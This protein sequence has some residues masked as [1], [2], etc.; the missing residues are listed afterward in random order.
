MQLIDAHTFDHVDYWFYEKESESVLSQ[1]CGCAALLQGGFVW[2]IAA[3]VL[4][5][6]CALN[7]P[8]GI[9]KDPC[10][11]FSVWDQNGQLLVD[12]E[13]TP[14]E[15]EVICGNYLCYTGR[16]NQMSKKSWFPL[17]HVYEGSREDHGRWTES[18]DT[19]YTNRIGAISG[20]CPNAAFCELLTSTMWRLR[21]RGTPDG[22]RAVKHWEELLCEFLSLHI[23]H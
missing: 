19:I 3:N 4:S 5:V 23:S 14:E 13:L 15:Y 21:L 6:E 7:G 2:R 1:W 22:H 18:I 12:D 10:H 11:M 9:Y 8:S 17:L 16:G 20:S